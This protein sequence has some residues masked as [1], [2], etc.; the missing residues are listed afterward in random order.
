VTA[1]EPDEAE[2]AAAASPDV[3]AVAGGDGSLAPAAL[4]ASSVEAALAVIPA[5]TANDFARALEVPDDLDRACELAA[6]GLSER[7]LDIGLMGNRPFLN[8]ASAGLPPAAAVRA[9]GLKGALGPLAYAVGAIRAGITA[10]PL[11]CEVRCDGRSIF[12]GD[13]WQVTVAC[14]GSFGAGSSVDADPEDGRLDVVVI[15]AGPRARL[16]AHAYGLRAGSVERQP[17]TRDCRCAEAEVEVAEGTLFNVDGE[18][19]EAG[20]VRFAIKPRA[21]RVIVP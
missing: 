5:G 7:R 10:D 15:E 8:A 19:V 6:A 18:I 9:K 14:T 20:P 2:A 12:A 3:I 16:V 11:P 1:F 21:V 13:A 4:A 17:D